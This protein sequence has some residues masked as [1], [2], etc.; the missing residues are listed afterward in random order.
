M[1][2]KQIGFAKSTSKRTGELCASDADLFTVSDTS[3]APVDATGSPA[4]PSPAPTSS[5]N[6]QTDAPQSEKAEEIVETP[7]PAPKETDSPKEIEEPTTEP[8]PAPSK[9]VGDMALNPDNNGME[10]STSPTDEEDGD[11]SSDKNQAMSIV[12][13]ASAATLGIFL[14]AG[15]CAG[16]VVLTRRHSTRHR[17]T[18]L[19]LD[20][21]G[22]MEMANGGGSSRGLRS[23]GS[24][25]SVTGAE[26]DFLQAGPGGYRSSGSGSHMY[27]VAE[28]GANS[29]G[30]GNGVLAS[31]DDEEGDDEVEVDFGSGSG[32][33]MEARR[34]AGLGR[35]F[36]PGR[37]GFAAFDDSSESM[38][39]TR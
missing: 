18:K 30:R 23:G 31:A 36:G 4:S 25:T 39:G 1:R 17:H 10:T 19:G 29:G 28:N 32:A 11:D 20:H 22:S 7:T 9:P 38:M 37:A 33:G 16:A 35:L 6:P 14:I 24:M 27:R 5:T 12:T 3:P 21:N 8:T 15:V 13:V 2:D 34:P 26:D